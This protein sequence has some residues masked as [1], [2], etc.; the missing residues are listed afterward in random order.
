[1]AEM[2]DSLILGHIYV[3]AIF[4]FV[5]WLGPAVSSLSNVQ[6]VDLHI[7]FKINVL[8]EINDYWI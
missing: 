3:L 7:L 4:D 2:G 8:N 1:M 6:S 5:L